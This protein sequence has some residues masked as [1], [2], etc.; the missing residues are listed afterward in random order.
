[1]K[2]LIV[3][4]AMAAWTVAAAS[5]AV[6]LAEKGKSAYT[7][8]L[9]S[10]ASASE[11]RAAHELQRFIEEMSGAK[12]PIVTDAQTPRGP[13][14]FVGDSPAL[15]RL[16][17][18]LPLA[19]VGPEGFVIRTHGRDVIIAGGRQR[20]TMY[21]VTAFL[22]RLGCRWFTSDVSHI[23][24]TPTIRLDALDVTE[25]PAFEYR[26]PFFT[27]AFEKDW[28]ARNRTN[29]AHSR[30]DDTT[31]GKLQY[32]PFVH[33]FYQLAPAGEALQGTPRVLLADRRQAPRASAA[34]CASPTP[35]CC[36]SQQSR[37]KHGSRSIRKRRSTRSRRTTG[38]VGAS[39]TAAAAWS[40]KKAA[41]TWVPCCDS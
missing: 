11:Q 19:G 31:G 13:R 9:A 37:S 3:C 26:E 1:M 21:G 40:R 33:T 25:K 12:L 27:E 15:Q 7:I 17:L 30:L 36:A 14:L 8:V 23:P 24:K 20:G 10:N 34:S 22:E 41:S 39:A 28:A 18:N 4:L 2:Q 29:G 6:T 38:K 32:Y 16:K 35:R 5:G